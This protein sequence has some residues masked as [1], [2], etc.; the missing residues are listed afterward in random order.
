LRPKKS[1]SGQRLYSNLD[2]ELAKE[3]KG[4]LYNE[5]LTID[6]ARKRLAQGSKKP[7]GCSDEVEKLKQVVRQAVDQL[8]ELKNRL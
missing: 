7:V 3:I 5:K 6:G 2:L 8:K 1:K 4:L